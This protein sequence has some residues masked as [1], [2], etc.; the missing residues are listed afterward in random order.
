MDRQRRHPRSTVEQLA[1]LAEKAGIFL[2]ELAVAFVVDHP[3]VTSAIIGPRTMDQQEEFLPAADTTLSSDVLDAVEA[4]DEIVA[5]GVTV[6][7]IGNSYGDF[8]LRADQR[9]R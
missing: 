1:V 2:I 6:N 3:G 9:R 7:P 8:E 5:P 4:I